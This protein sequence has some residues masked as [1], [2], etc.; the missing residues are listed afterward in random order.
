MKVSVISFGDVMCLCSVFIA[1]LEDLGTRLL[2]LCD[3]YLVNKVMLGS[4]Q[5]A[6]LLL[7][8]LA[9]MRGLSLVA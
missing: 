7:F 9:L 1:T 2:P 4:K 3:L 8:P 5:R 6:K